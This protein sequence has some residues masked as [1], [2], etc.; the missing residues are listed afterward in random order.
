MTAARPPAAVLFDLD[1]T[2]ADTLADI[3]TALDAAR[4]AEGHPPVGDPALVRS[5]IGDGAR[6]LCARSLGSEDVTLPA[7]RR[8]R[9]AFRA[10]YPSISGRL[11]RPYDGVVPLC[12]E[13]RAA[14]RRTALTTNKPRVATRAF[15]D[16]HALH[17]R[18]DAVVTP[19]DVGD[20]PKPDPALFLRA[21][22]LLA[23]APADCLVVGD[24]AADVLGARAAGMRVVAVL[25]GYGDA[26]RLRALAPD[27]C[28]TYAA[29]LRHAPLLGLV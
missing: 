2:V 3:V 6:A 11:S 17:A 1:G 22:E 25:G 27:L 20:R 26:D 24:G 19:D 7:A 4:A 8:L 18:F 16:V 10:V 12:D 9:D 28:V 21:A 13:L 15:L 29:E 14:G 23:C 5:W